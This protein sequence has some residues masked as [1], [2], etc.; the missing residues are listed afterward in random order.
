MEELAQSIIRSVPLLGGVPLWTMTLLLIMASAVVILVFALTFEGVGSLVLRKVAGDIQA[1]I[2]PNRVGPNG[3][4]QFLADGVKLVLKEDIIPAQADRFLFQLA[5]YLVFVG[6]FAAFVV[7]PFGVGLTAADLNIGI[8]YVM[9][10]TSLVV[11][12]VLLAGWSS[13][14]KWALLGGMRAAAQIVSYE[15]PVGMALLPAVLVAGSLSL[16]D[17]VRSQGG[18][19]G[20][21][22]WNLFH[23]PFSFFSFFLYFTAA[24]AE[25]NQTPFD[26][27]E[28]ESELVSGYN[29]EYSGIRFGL[30]FLAE[31]GDM[32][33]VAALA[34][35]C[36]LGGWQ[37][38]FFNAA[39]LP[40]VWGNLLSLGV[41]LSKAFLMVLVMMWVRWT[42][43]RLRVDQLMRMSWKYMVPLTFVNLL[44]VSLWLLVFRGKGIPGMIASLFG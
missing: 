23:N 7:V 34:T 33:I 15:I 13:N 39:A 30:F 36:F 5:P 44:G 25:T 19:L 37:V 6:S 10:I 3:M 28:A 38:P 31:F 26:L 8:Y 4:L 29:V 18:L 2:G 20:I 9:A 27:P 32:F 17:I 11:V 35:A 1:R 42:L 22:G 24:Q 43:P 40:P 14:N 21:F 12:G 16:Q 41:F